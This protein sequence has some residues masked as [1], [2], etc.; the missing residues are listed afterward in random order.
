MNELL[1]EI[2]NNPQITTKG[3]VKAN[4]YLT[5]M[6]EN[7]IMSKLN[8][9]Y[10]LSILKD[11]TDEYITKKQSRIN[12][13]KQ[14]NINEKFKA[15]KKKS[16]VFL[17][18]SK[19]NPLQKFTYDTMAHFREGDLIVA[20]FQLASQQN[21]KRANEFNERVDNLFFFNA[22]IMGIQREE[23]G[24]GNPGEEF[25]MAYDD[26]FNAF[27]DLL[28]MGIDVTKLTSTQIEELYQANLA[29]NQ[30]K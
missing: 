9:G 18:I 8:I 25:L 23:A 10:V 1:E 21:P 24:N 17:D 16:N 6:L 27:N 4:F 5:S 7:T 28:Q 13:L 29:S 11:P 3:I 20:A 30:L 26:V 2:S 14:A 12:W 22:R 15:M 19:L